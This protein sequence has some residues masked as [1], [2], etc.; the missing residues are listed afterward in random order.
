MLK[1]VVKQVKTIKQNVNTTT[2]K[3]P[4]QFA[5]KFRQACLKGVQKRRK[6][7]NMIGDMEES[8]PF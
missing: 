5:K 3:L 7:T 1:L 6:T 8:S 2:V 4:S